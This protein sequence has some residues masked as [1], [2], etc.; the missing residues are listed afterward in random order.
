[1]R[2]KNTL[3]L[4]AKAPVICRVKTR[5]W[6]TLTHRECL[7][8]HRQLVS[9]IL[10]SFKHK[11]NLVFYT[12]R[13]IGYSGSIR[14]QNGQDLGMRMFNAMNEELKHSQKVILVGSDCPQLDEAYINHAFASL[15][16]M[17][18]ITFG[19]S[20]DGG[21]FLIGAKRVLP[22]L[23]SQMTWS[24]S[25]VLNE[26]LIKSDRLGFNSKLLEPLTDIDTIDDLQALRQSN[27]LPVWAK[28]LL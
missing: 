23:F 22:G 10:D 7:Y 8:L 13:P 6:P 28:R 20:N 17:R 14:I 9:H 26:T 27:S 5:M 25:N 24:D 16:G 11:F 4:F 3:I 19:P 12:T 2:Y 15:E 18:D 1:M 21:Y